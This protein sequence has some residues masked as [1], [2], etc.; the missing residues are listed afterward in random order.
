MSKNISPLDM[1]GNKVTNLGLPTAANDAANKTYVDTIFNNADYKASARLATTVAIT[2]NGLLTVDGT[3]TI[4]GD[5]VLV[6]QH[7]GGQQLSGIFV[8]GTGP[9]LL[10]EDFN[11]ASEVS[12]GALVYVSEGATNGGGVF[13][14]ST[15]DPVVL[16]TTALTWVRTN[17]S[18]NNVFRQVLASVA[19]TQTITHNRGNANVLVQLKETV[20]VTGTVVGVDFTNFTVNT[21]DV[22]FATAPTSGQYEIIVVG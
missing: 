8:V 11:A 20:A 5:R 10:A 18:T 14:L 15:P 22:V 7:S 2:P 4:V 13:V 1:S 6:K 19:L 12:S 17:A 3:A 16:G 21:V 9:W